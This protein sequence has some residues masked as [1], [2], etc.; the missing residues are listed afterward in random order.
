MKPD[1]FPDGTRRPTFGGHGVIVSIPTEDADAKYHELKVA[2]V[3][4]LT[5]PEDKPWGW[6]S[7]VVTDPNRLL[8]DFFHVYREAALAS[9]A[10]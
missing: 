1:G 6:R 8:L 2:G 7:F 10:E 5:P 4:V 3:E 9:G